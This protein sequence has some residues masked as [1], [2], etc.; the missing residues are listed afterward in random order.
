[1][2]HRIM[3]D[4]EDHCD[5]F[6]FST[7]LHY[8]QNCQI[9]KSRTSHTKHKTTLKNVIWMVKN[10]FHW[11]QWLFTFNF[12]LSM[13]KYIILT[14]SLLREYS[15]SEN[16]FEFGLTSIWRNMLKPKKIWKEWMVL[17]NQQT[18]FPSL[19]NSSFQTIRRK[20]SW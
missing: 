14:T 13:F 2:S 7:I 9:S 8:H 18:E 10:H 17:S 5:H 16:Q 3:N 6:C 1:M 12:T 19:T 15:F 4:L 20:T 11:L